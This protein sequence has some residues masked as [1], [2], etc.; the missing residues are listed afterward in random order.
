MGPSTTKNVTGQKFS[1][2][3]FVTSLEPGPLVFTCSNFFSSLA[4]RVSK[5]LNKDFASSTE[6]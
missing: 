5:F 6:E 2:E 1:F 3:P 4:Y